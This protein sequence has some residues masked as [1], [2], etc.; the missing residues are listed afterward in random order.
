V[1]R[2]D[3]Q[4]RFGA[5][6][7]REKRPRAAGHHRQQRGARECFPDSGSAH[8]CPCITL[9]SGGSIAAGKRGISDQ[10]ALNERDGFRPGDRF[11]ADLGLRYDLAHG[12]WA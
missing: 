12:A 2:A 6:R 1:N 9:N 10:E 4:I 11:T 5:Y 3:F 7:M 8:Q